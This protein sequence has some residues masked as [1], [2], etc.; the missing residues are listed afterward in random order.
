MEAKEWGVKANLAEPRSAI[1]TG[2]L[3]WVINTNP[4]WGG[5]RILVFARSRS[6]RWI[7]TWISTKV[8]TN[9]RAAWVHEGLRNKCHLWVGKDDASQWAEAMMGKWITDLI[10]DP[11]DT[12]D[13]GKRG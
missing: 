6:G 5:E 1:R 7:E 2:A 12:V 3:V 8:L 4:G 13:H 9:L 11:S 10:K